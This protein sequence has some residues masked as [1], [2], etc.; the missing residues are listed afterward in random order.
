MQLQIES[1]DGLIGVQR[2][3]LREKVVVMDGSCCYTE[4]L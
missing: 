4:D 2:V 1:E 3:R